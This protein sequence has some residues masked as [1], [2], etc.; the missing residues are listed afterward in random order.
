MKQLNTNIFRFLIFGFIFLSSYSVAHATHLRAG[1]ITASQLSPNSLTYR[2]TLIVYRDTRGVPADPQ[3]TLVIQPGGVS[4][5]APLLDEV[6]V[7]PLITRVRYVFT[8]TFPGAGTYRLGYR[9]QFR[10]GCTVNM[11]NALETDL[12]VESQLVIQPFVGVN[13]SPILLAPPVDQAALG[14]KFLHNPAAYDPDGDSLS[15]KLVTPKRNFDTEV[16]NYRPLNNY[17]SAISES[18]GTPF[19]G[20]DPVTGTVTWDAPGGLANG[21]CVNIAIK[22]EEWRK[23]VNAQGQVSYV[24]LGYVVRDMQIVVTQTTNRRPLLQ[25]PGDACVAAT[26]ESLN[27]VITATDPDGHSVQITATGQVFDSS[28]PAPR[29]SFDG[30]TFQW[31]PSCEH[32]RAQPYQIVFK[33]QDNPPPSLGEPLVDIKVW[34]IKVVGPKPVNLQANV[35]NA[36]DEITL[37]WDPY[38]CA[39]KAQKLIVWRKDGC[40]SGNPMNCDTGAPD[41]QG[42]VAIAELPPTATSYT[43][44]RVKVGRR[45]SYRISAVFP[46]PAGGESYASD[47]VCV[48][49][50]IDV[51]LFTKVDITNTD[52]NNGS[53]EVNFIQPFQFPN[54]TPPS[55]FGY[56]VYRGEGLD[57]NANTPVFS[58][59]NV[60][61]A[62]RSIISFIDNGLNTLDKSYHYRIAFFSNATDANSA[63]FVDSSDVASTVRLSLTPKSNCIDLR[64]DYNTPWSNALQNHDIFQSLNSAGSFN[65]LAQFMPTVTEYGFYTDTGAGQDNTTYFYY[66]LTR[67]SYYNDDIT[68]EYPSLSVPL[69]NRSQI[70]SAQPDDQVPPCPPV[71]SVQAIDCATFDFTAGPPF[72]NQLQWSFN[73]GNGSGSGSCGETIN[74]CEYEASNIAVFRI[75]YKPNTEASY[76]S[77]IAEVSGTQFSF[78]HGGLNSL[79]GCYVITAVDQSGNE[80]AFSNEVCVD[81]C[82]QFKLPNVFTPNGDGFNDVFT[83][84]EPLLFVESIE[85]EVVNRW[86]KRVFYSASDPAINWNGRY[87]PDGNSSGGSELPSGVYYYIA[88]VRFLRVDPKNSEQLFQGWIHLLR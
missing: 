6:P 54:G 30:T 22:V 53:I 85:F 41:G 32:I 56:V 63:V 25:V 20:I 19:Y 70:N 78:T 28:F 34:N 37:T 64:W 17:L 35:D 14:Q 52:A 88:K 2:I 58:L 62:D 74:G 46:P 38:V 44:K 65:L 57:G 69:V 82:I 80:S 86:G 67:G 72:S 15:F 76:G 42:Y 47:E 51:P 29:A 59:Y 18:G 55:P 66:I 33:A 5:T 60:N 1:Q 68:N 87:N 13:N 27:E 79:A 43:D 81:N 3:A 10:N 50:A 24:F 83:P 36:N 11:S 40:S 39:A 23:V 71:L 77:P 12:F 7:A 9:E 48:A 16:S 75:Y 61:P 8:Y 84:L 45:Y 31:A 26:Q 4:L 21:S 73:N 49:L